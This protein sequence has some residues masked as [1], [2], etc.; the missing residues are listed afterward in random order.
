[1]DNDSTNINLSEDSNGEVW[2][3]WAGNKF[4]IVWDGWKCYKISY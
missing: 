4:N 1:M 2:I 3:E